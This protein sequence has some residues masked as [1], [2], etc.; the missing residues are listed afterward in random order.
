MTRKKKAENKEDDDS[1]EVY[2]EKFCKCGEWKKDGYVGCHAEGCDS[3]WHWGCIGWTNLTDELIKALSAKEM[4]WN[5]PACIMKEMTGEND[6]N[7]GDDVATVVKTELA[8]LLPTIVTEVVNATTEKQTKKWSSLLKENTEENKK[9]IKTTM[10]DNHEKVVKTAIMKMDSDHVERE[11]RKKNIVIKGVP[12]SKKKT[13]REKTEEDFDFVQCLLELD[14]D[15]IWYVTRAGPQLGSLPNDQRTCRPLIAS[16]SSP[17]LASQKHGHGRGK[18]WYMMSEMGDT[19]RDEY[20]YVNQ[21]LIYSD[22]KADYDARQAR[23]AKKFKASDVPPD[24]T[25]KKAVPEPIISEPATEP[26]IP[27]PATDPVIP[28]PAAKTPLLE[29]PVIN[30]STSSSSDFQ[31]S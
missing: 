4:I 26:V 8:R 12:E 14:E 1:G 9:T 13:Q 16:L 30:D 23:N 3:W 29:T 25:T 11:K 17:E 31:K 6:N 20:F 21:D 18:K 7:G 10:E 5:C 22:R 24:Q 2:V 15:D 27:E 28:E 19:S